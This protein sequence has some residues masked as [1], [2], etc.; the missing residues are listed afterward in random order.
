MRA[1]YIHNLSV[2]SPGFLRDIHRQAVQKCVWYRIIIGFE[3]G[4]FNLTIGL[5]E[6]EKSLRLSK[7]LEDIVAKI[8]MVCMR[9]FTR[10]PLEIGLGKAV[11]V[12]WQA[13]GFGS[14][15]AESWL[16]DSRFSLWL[17]L[18]N[19]YCSCGGYHN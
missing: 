16:K 18:N 19:L 5:V 12:V 1:R 15:V 13:V 17:T 8:K 4:I 3:C 14:S 6:G 9:V 7:V 10:H 11:K 2:T